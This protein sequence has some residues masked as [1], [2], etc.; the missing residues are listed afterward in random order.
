MS[1]QKEQAPEKLPSFFLHILHLIIGIRSVARATIVATDY[2][3][4]KTNTGSHFTVKTIKDI[5]SVCDIVCFA[6][7]KVT[8]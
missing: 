3:A 2:L 1:S 5:F 8:N 7:A 6:V 4:P